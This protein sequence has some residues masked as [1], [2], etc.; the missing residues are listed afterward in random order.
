MTMG[1]D[2]HV[3]AIPFQSTQDSIGKLFEQ[4]LIGFFLNCR[5]GGGGH[6]KI[7]LHGLANLIIM[8]NDGSS[9]CWKGF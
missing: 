3:N 2:L 1:Y 8:I 4:I 7:M 9:W 5:M 6:I